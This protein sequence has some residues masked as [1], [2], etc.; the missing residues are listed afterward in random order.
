MHH[1]HKVRAMRIMLRIA[2]LIL[3][4]YNSRE[5]LLY[6]G[7]IYHSAQMNFAARLPARMI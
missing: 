6:N 7:V 2:P 3:L 5:V 4:L 1:Q